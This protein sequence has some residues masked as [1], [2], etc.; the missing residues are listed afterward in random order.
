[1]QFTPRSGMLDADSFVSQADTPAYKESI[2]LFTVG[3]QTMCQGAFGGDKDCSKPFVELEEITDVSPRP[4]HNALRRVWGEASAARV[5]D[6]SWRD[7]AAVCWGFGK[8]VGD[9]LWEGRR[10]WCDFCG[11]VFVGRKEAVV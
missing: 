8:E 11:G 1:M 7:F 3:M 9:C 10:R 5:G 6:Q 4:D 2:R